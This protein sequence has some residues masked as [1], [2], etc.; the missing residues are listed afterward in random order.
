MSTLSLNKQDKVISTS[1]VSV[2][3]KLPMDLIL[4]LH[5]KVTRH[6]PVMGGGTRTYDIFQKRFPAQT[7]VVKGNAYAQNKGPEDKQISAGYAITHGIPK[8]FWDEWVEQQ[9]EH[10]AVKNHMVF[11]HVESA[12]TIAQAKECEAT[13]SGME[14]LDPNDMHQH[15]L[16]RNDQKAA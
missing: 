2:A 7:F 6:E 10:E 16:M 14:R 8:A 13:R 11:A 15:G 5:D 9:A 1:T 12:S 4:H 3:S